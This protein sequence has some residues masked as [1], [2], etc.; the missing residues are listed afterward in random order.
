MIA[1]DK[2]EKQLTGELFRQ[3]DIERLR[4]Y[5]PAHLLVDWYI[6]ILEK[7]RLSGACFSISEDDDLSEMGVDIKWFSSEQIVD[8]ALNAYPG[9]SVMKQGY[10]PV[11]T[12]LSGSG[13]PYFL[14]VS[15]EPGLSALVRV[16]HYVAS[17]DDYP[18]E[19]I[20]KVSESLNHFFELATID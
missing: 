8:E 1:L 4:K 16:P 17:D 7:Y 10:L 3:S 14:K 15:K 19:D 11:G 5:L 18:E 6:E 20:E 2:I 9:K 13:D 12:C